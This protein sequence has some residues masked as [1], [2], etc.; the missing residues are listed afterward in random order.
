VVLFSLTNGRKSLT[1][2]PKKKKN[3]APSASLVGRD[4]YQRLFK[5]LQSHCSTIAAQASG[6]RGETLLSFFTAE[7][8]YF[9]FSSKV[10]NHIFA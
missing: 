6:M 2:T 8:D 9:T 10:L 3:W 1:V 7:W 4:L 5:L